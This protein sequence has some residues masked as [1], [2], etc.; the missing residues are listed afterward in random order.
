MI[1]NGFSISYL[2]NPRSFLRATFEDMFEMASGI[3]LQDAG[4]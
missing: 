4:V 3:F 2:K 1:G